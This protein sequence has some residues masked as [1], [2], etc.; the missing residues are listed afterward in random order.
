MD[1]GIW[2]EV[3]GLLARRPKSRHCLVDNTFTKVQ[4]AEQRAR[5]ESK[6]QTIGFTKGGHNSK[7]TA[8][9]DEGGRVVALLLFPGQ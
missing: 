2:A 1:G 9:V 3:L 7:L 5:G 8:A 6:N 4:Q